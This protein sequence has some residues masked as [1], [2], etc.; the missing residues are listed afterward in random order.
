MV[1][2]WWWMVPSGRVQVA[3]RSGVMVSVQRPS[4]TRWWWRS[5]SG[6]KLSMSVEPRSRVHPSD[7]MD[8]GVVEGDGAVGVGAGAVYCS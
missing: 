3:T 2:P 8:L 5:Q 1:D 6:S 7:V 4:W